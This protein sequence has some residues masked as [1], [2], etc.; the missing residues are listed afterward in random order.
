M[1][2]SLKPTVIVGKDELTENI[3]KEIQVGLYNHEIVKVSS[4]KSCTSSAKQMCAEVCQILGCEP[5]LCIGNRFVVYSRSN[6]EGIEHI[7]L[8]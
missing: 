4:L 8:D 2:N 5:V 1:A 7:S 6:K 3:I